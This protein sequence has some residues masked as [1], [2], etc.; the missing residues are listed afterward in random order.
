MPT[1]P[2]A[3]CEPGV[4]TASTASSAAM[5]TASCV[6]VGLA[7]GQLLQL[8]ARPHDASAPS[9]CGGCLP[10]SL[11]I[12]NEMPAISGTPTIREATSQYQAGRPSG[13]KTKI[14]TII[15][16]SRKLVPQRGCRREKR[17]AFSGVERHAGLVAG[18]RLV[19]GA[20]VLEHAPQ[21]GQA[22]EQPQVAEEDRGAHD[23]LDDP[24]QERRAELVLEQAREADRDDEEQAD[25][26]RERDDDV[27]THMPPE[28][29]CSSSPSWALAEMPSALKPIFSDSTSAT[30]P[31]M[32]GQRSSG[33]A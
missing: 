10:A 13:A 15:T 23:A 14:A 9:A 17:C 26:E 12:S 24:E 18:D 3:L 1:G 8:H 33:G 28:I 16:I 5:A 30:T 31:R 27:P 4:S 11:M 6:E 2:S 21:V 7:R 19:L 20:V 29:S 32:I 22:R 25:R